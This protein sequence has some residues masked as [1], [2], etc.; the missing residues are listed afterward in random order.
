M[1]VVNRAGRAMRQSHKRLDPVSITVSRDGREF[2]CTATVGETVVDEVTADNTVVTSR[3]RSFF[4]DASDYNFGDGPVNP[5]QGDEF[6][7]P[8]GVFIVAMDS[9][10]GSWT[11]S[12]RARTYYRIN[13][14]E[15]S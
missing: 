3:Q 7:T 5:E 14:V 1:S 4:V 13:T 2:T 6:N 8:N 12:D 11:F 15:A 9:A 10:N